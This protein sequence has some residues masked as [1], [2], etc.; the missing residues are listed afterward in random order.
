MATKDS[1]GRTLGV[2]LG[3]SLVCSLLVSV[4][5]VS[6]RPKQA[7][8]RLLNRK[9][10]ILRAAGVLRADMSVAEQYEGI[11]P[12]VVDLETGEYVENVDPTGFDQQAA[13][14]D[15]ARSVAIPDSQDLAGIN[16]RAKRAAVYLVE[17]EGRVDKVILPVHGLG[18]WSTMYGFVALDARDLNTI[19]GL[20]FFEHGETPG[21]GGEIDDPDWQA[22]WEGKKVYGP[23]GDVRIDV[24]KGKVDPAREGAQFKV[25]G[26]SGATL[27]S[28]G[29]D[30]MLDYWLGENGFG[31]YLRKMRE[32]GV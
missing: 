29:V 15:P 16:R 30:R 2:A 17:K 5:A 27:T 8:N 9:K 32:R 21:L 20:V 19:R 25:D 22:L 18:L 12:R 1:V 31:I 6:L 26:L 14:R 24:I 11:R 28:R 3:V 23:D 10:N 13:A 7:E 4:A